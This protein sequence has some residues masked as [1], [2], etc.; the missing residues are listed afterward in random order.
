MVG[1]MAAVF[2]IAQIV[3]AIP[4]GFATDRYKY[5]SNFNFIALSFEV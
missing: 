1:S 5:A 2:G 4:A 3:A